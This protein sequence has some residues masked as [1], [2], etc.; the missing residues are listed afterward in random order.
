MDAR[1]VWIAPDVGFNDIEGTYD[2][3]FVGVV[4]RSMIS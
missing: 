3:L 4:E 2:P 1:S